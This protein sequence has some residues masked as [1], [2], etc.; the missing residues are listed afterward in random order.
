MLEGNLQE[1]ERSISSPLCVETSHQ[2]PMQNS[3]I[4]TCPRHSAIMHLA[5][6]PRS[7]RS[8]EQQTLG[9][10]AY[11]AGVRHKHHP[12]HKAS[13]GS[14]DSLGSSLSIE[15]NLKRPPVYHPHSQQNG[16]SVGS[17]G[18]QSPWC[19]EISV[20]QAMHEFSERFDTARDLLYKGVPVTVWDK[21]VPCKQ[22][23]IVKLINEL[24]IPKEAPQLQFT[25]SRS[26]LVW[27][28][29]CK[30]F[31][32]DCKTQIQMGA[33]RE[34]G[35]GLDPDDELSVTLFRVSENLG[36]SERSLVMRC[37][38]ERTCRDL[39]SAIRTI[40]TETALRASGVRTVDDDPAE[41]STSKV[42]LEPDQSNPF[43][44]R[45]SQLESELAEECKKCQQILLQMMEAANDGNNKE[46]E[47]NVLRAELRNL[48]DDIKDMKQVSSTQMNMYSKTM[49][50]M[51]AYQFECEE[52]QLENAILRQKA[53]V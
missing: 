34:C 7:P 29:P 41:E 10:R 3:Q 11:L 25:S 35:G 20:K 21:S 37:S 32:L 12:L 5:K 2:N 4:E 40:L 46:V 8:S 19:G 36:G 39:F 44:E 1:R 47:I 49:K 33:R 50:R 42:T 43:S 38:E 6:S 9:T 22:E 16:S 14:L 24:G 48:E 28:Q 17:T 53:A 13:I 18:P 23:L 45:I 15:S 51:E 30:P 26:Y 52:L 27:R 31:D